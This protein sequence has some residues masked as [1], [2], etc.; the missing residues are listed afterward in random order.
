MRK[1]LALLAILSLTTLQ[2]S[3]F[4]TGPSAVSWSRVKYNMAI[5]RSASEELLLNLVR[6][7]YREAPFF[8]QIASVS[9]SLEAEISS[10]ANASFP[11][12]AD[13]VYGLNLGGSYSESPTITYTPV[14]GEAYA[15]QMLTPVS[16]EKL[17]LLLN[18]GWSI[19]R[20]FQVTLQELNGLENAMRAT[21]P[22]PQMAPKFDQFSHALDLLRELQLREM[23]R[24]QFVR[25]QDEIRLALVFTEES[26][27]LPE[28]EE[29]YE[30][31]NLSK[32]RTFFI[33]SPESGPQYLTCIPRPIVS[34]LFYLSQGVQVPESHL[35]KGYVTQ[36]FDSE[37]I[38]FDWNQIIG[39]VFQIKVTDNQLIAKQA[40]N[41]V[42]YRGKWFY[43][44]D[45]DLNSKSTFLLTQQL[46]SLQS[47]ETKTNAPILTIPVGGG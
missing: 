35:E 28:R 16:M 2:S 40:D 46:L 33:M 5:Q 41:H 25:D 4:R 21:G 17:A 15:R 39:R 11:I 34:S 38:P 13:D 26:E 10:G 23:I 42:Y 1:L 30:L 14:H 7:R 45:D 32:N 18:S 6:L 44:P 22:T 29:L 31:L 20:T 19:S 27:G 24:V 12:N 8:L 36:T 47:G 43:I 37:G 3:C 9:Q